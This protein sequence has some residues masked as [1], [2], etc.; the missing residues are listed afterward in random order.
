MGKDSTQ[1]DEDFRDAVW[2]LDGVG[3]IS[4]LVKT[5]FGYH[6]IKVID[7]LEEGPVNYDD[8]KEKIEKA[9]HRI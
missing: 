5:Q 6:I 9:A 4:G 1:Y 7:E 8:V 2:A 3:S